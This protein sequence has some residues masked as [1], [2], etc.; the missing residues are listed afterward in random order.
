MGAFTFLDDEQTKQSGGSFTFLDNGAESDSSPASTIKN[1]G[2]GIIAGAGE[3]VANTEAAIGTFLQAPAANTLSGVVGARALADRG[4]TAAINAVSPGSAKV[5]PEY[6]ESAQ[7]ASQF[8]AETRAE[9]A[10]P[11]IGA[12]VARALEEDGRSRAQ[13]IQNFNR[14]N[15]PELIRQQ[16]ATAEAEGFVDNLKAI[17]DNPLAFANTMARSAPDMALGA[18]VARKVAQ[19]VAAAGGSA[20][21]QVGA[22]ST[23]GMLSEAGSSAMQ[24]REGVYQQV[25]AIPLTRLLES[26]R[27]QEILAKTKDPVQAREV[28]ANELADQAPLLAGTGTALGTIITNR[29]FGGDT[30]AKVLAGTER[31][32]AKDVAK[33]LAQES[34]EE[35]LQ[36]VPEDLA[37]HGAVVQAD[38]NKKFDVGGTLA[39]NM[40]A[41]AAMG[42][43]GTLAA[44][45]KQSYDDFK[46]GGP[47]DGQAAGTPPADTPTAADVLGVPESEQKQTAAEKAL[48][49]PKRL[50][51]LDRVEA[52]DTELQ[53][54]TPERSA[55]LI[56]EREAI[57]K[58]WPA[59]VEGGETTFST[60][61]GA[62][63]GAKYALIEAGDL[64]TSHDENL[65]PSAVYPSELQPRE[66]D[67]HASEMQVSGIVQKLDPARLGLS[68][69]AA[70]GAPI[71]GADGLVESGNARSI[72]LKRIY[73]AN[74]QKA[75]DYKTFIRSNAAQFGI[76]PAAVDAMQ[77]PVLVRVR[78]TPVN[79]A[80][81]ARQANA[82]TV[83]QMSPSEQARSD[84]ARLDVLD[85][86]RPTEDGDFSTSRDFIRRFMAK[87]PAT[88]QAGML[89]S[90]GQLSQTG[91]ARIRNAVLAKAYG[92]SPVLVRMVESMDDNLRNI[93]KALMQAAP[94]VAKVRQ[95]VADGALFDADITPDLMAAVEE[96]SVLRDGGRSVQDALAQAGMFGDKYS[97]ETRDL[98]QF[99]DE[100]IRRPKQMAEF[101][102]RY[103]EALRAAGNPNQGS[104]LGE[105]AAPNKGDLLTAAKR[106][107]D[108]VERP[109]SG[110]GAGTE[111]RGKSEVAQGHQGSAQGDESQSEWV[112][113]PP[114]TGTLGIPR[115]EMP[116]VKGD[117]RGAL[118]QFLEARRI[119]NKTIEEYPSDELK[120]TQAEFST[121]KTEGWKDVKEGSDRS[122][123][124]S[125]DGYILDGH[126][127]WMAALAT[128]EPI[129]AI[130][131]D[132]PIRELLAAV[133]Q[134]PST[135]RSTESASDAKRTKARED[136]DA[137]L[138]ELG[139]FFRQLSPGV[140][141][142]TPE[143]KAKLMP[144]LVKL[145]EAGIKEIGYNIKDLI[146][147]VKKAM[148]SRPELKAFWNRVDEATYR[149][150]AKSAVDNAINGLAEPAGQGDLFSLPERRAAQQDLF[151][152]MA[153]EA[154]KVAM[155]DGRP[156]DMKRD[157]FSPPDPSTFIG[158]QQLSDA[159]ALIDRFFSGSAQPVV[160]I[161]EAEKEQARTALAP[162]IELAETGKVRFDQAIID[163]A[164]NHGIG[165]LI[166]PIKT[167]DSA[168]RKVV[169]EYQGDASKVADLL[170]ATVVVERYDDAAA[171]IKAL[172]KQFDVVN[173]KNKAAADLSNIGTDL[174]AK[175]KN[176]DRAVFGGYADV[177]V[178]IRDGSGVLAEVQI[179]IPAMLAIKD[180]EGHR[181]YEAARVQSDGSQEKTALNSAMQE[182]YGAAFAADTLRAS[183]AQFKNAASDDAWHLETGSPRMAASSTLS[184]S[185]RNQEP[186]GNLTNSSP[187]NDDRNSQPSGNLSGTFISGTS[188]ES[189]AENTALNDLDHFTLTRLDQ[190]TQRM[191]PVTF[192]RGE[193]VR[194]LL[195]G[196]KE[197]FGEIDGI[198]HARREFSVDGL[199]YPFG[200]AYKA[201]RPEEKKRANAVPLSSVID[202][203]N[204]KFGEGLT[205]D[206]RVPPA[207]NGEAGI[208]PEWDS[209]AEFW[210]GLLEGKGSIADL[211]A[212]FATILDRAEEFKASIGKMKNDQLKRMLGWS[213]RPGDKKDALVDKVYDAALRRFVLDKNVPSMQWSYGE[214]YAKVKRDHNEKIRAI[215]NDLTDADLQAFR[216]SI[217]EADQ[218]KKAAHE[219]A[220]AAA[221]DPKTAEDFATYWNVARAEGKSLDEAR[222]A[223]TPEQRAA[224]DAFEASKTREARQA[225]GDQQKAEVKVAAQTTGGTIV[226]G[227]HTKHG[228]PLWSVQLSE[229]VDGDSYKTLLSTAKR[230]GGNYV[231]AMQ[232][233]MWKTVWG[234]QF[235]EQP[236]AEAFLK[237][238]GGESG[239]ARAVVQDR[240]DAFADDRSQSAVER[241]SEMAGRLDEQAD[242]SLG[243]ERKANTER[244][245]RFA[246]SAEAA[247]RAD[248]ALAATMRHIAD[249]IGSG[250]AKFLDR[251][252]QK[253]QV[254]MLAQT[255]RSAKDD[256][257]RAKYPSYGD[258][259]K[260][261]G[262]KPTIDTVEF[263]TWPRYTLFRSD[264]ATLGRQLLDVDGT[265]KLGQQLLKVADDVTDVYKKF[266]KENLHKVS[267]FSTKHPGSETVL[268]AVFSSSDA[269]ER[270]IARSGF[271]GKATTIS[272][273]RG[274]HL[275]IMGPSMARE[276]G[277][278]SGDDDKRITLS[279][280]FG[281]ELVEKVGRRSG[282]RS[283]LPAVPW[284][285]ANAYDKRKKLAA[286]GIETPFEFRA[287]LREFIALQQAPAEADKIKQMERAMIGR[288]ND[289]LDFFP[290]S[291]VVAD[292]MIDV[293]ELKPK[294]ST[295][296]PQAGMG[297]I[298][299]RIRQAGVE[300]DV[301]ELSQE[302]RELLE[303]KG[304]NV[305][306]QDFLAM[307]MSDTPNGEGY[308]RIIMN[309]PFSDRRD[310]EHVRHA[311]TLLKPGGRLVA[312]MGEG[313]FFGQD[314]KAA[315][316]RSWLDEVVGNSEKLPEGSFLDPSL[317]VN[318][319]VNARM[320]VVDKEADSVSNDGRLDQNDSNIA[321]SRGTGSGMSVR[322][323]KAVR[324]RVSERM[325]NLPPVNVLE[326]PAHAPEELRDFIEK[327]GA[328]SDVEGAMHDGEIYLFASGL[329][330]EERAEFVLATHEITHYGLRGRYGLGLDSVLQQIWLNNA[331]VRKAAT[332]LREKNGLGSNLEA[333]E[334]VLADM[335]SEDLV[336]LKGWRK[337]VAKVRDWFDRHGFEKLTEKLNRLLN[338]GLAEQ[339]Q[340]DVMVADV[341]RQARGFVESGRRGSGKYGTG[342]RLA[343]VPMSRKSG[344]EDP[345]N[346]QL[347]RAPT[348]TDV[349]KR[350]D[351]IIAKP[352]ASARPID[353]VVKAL[354]KSVRVDRMTLWAYNKAGALIDRLVPEHVKAGVVSDYGVPEAVIDRRTMMQGSMR[355]QVRG[356]GE[357][358]DK[359]ATL[360]REESRVAYEWMNN[361]DPQAAEYFEKQLPPESLKVMA[362]VKTLID[363][364]SQEAVKLGQLDPESFKRNRYEYLRRSYFKHTAELTKGEAEKRGRAISILGDQYKGRGMVDSVAMSKFRNVAPEWWGRKLQDG[365]AD[366][367]LKGE[368]FARLERRAPVGEGT[369]PLEQKHG[370][371][372]VDPLK[373]GRLLEVVYWPANE[374]VPAK[375][376]TW[377]HAGTWE[378]RDTKGG[379]LVLWRDFTKQER[380]AMGEIDEARFAIAKTLHGM[381]HD[382]E[383]GK[384]LE[385]LA[386]NHAQKDASQVTGKL[387]EATDRMRDTYGK[388]E[389]VQVPETTISGTSVKKYGALAGRYLPG[390][391]WNDVRQTV[392]FRFEPF[393]ETYAAILGAWKTSK[394]ALSPA[395]HTNNV[396][397][398]M[399][400]ADWHDVTA[401][402][403]VKALRL[404]LAA[405]DR[406]GEGAIGR[407]GNVVAKAGIADQ[408]AA[409][410]ILERFAESGGNIGT[411]AT[412]ELQKEQ[413]EPLLKALENEIATVA[414]SQPAQVGAMVALQKA[415]QLRFPS[416]WEAFK[417]T[418]AGKAL[419]TEARNMLDLYEAEDQVFRLAAWLRAKE[420]GASDIEAG[421]SARKSFLDY[422]IN[423]PWIQ[424]MRK[425]A[426]PFISFT[427]R[428]IPMLLETAATK[429]WKLLK[430]G[431]MAGALNM[432]GYLLSGGD[433]D[434]E[435][436]Y[437]PEEKAGRVLGV[438]PKLIRM[439][440]ND[441]N[442]SPVFLDIRR[443]VPV[444]DFLD[445]GQSHSAIPLIPS[446]VPGGVLSIMG[447]LV[448]NK[449]QFTGKEITRDTDTATEKTLKVV[450]HLYKAFAPN[451]VILPGTYAFQGVVDAGRGKTD[452]F[453]REQSTPAAVASSFGI[454]LGSYPTDVLRQ[455]ARRKMHS[456]KMEVQQGIRQLGREIRR[457]GID[458]DEYREK[459]EAQKEKKREIVQKFR[460]R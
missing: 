82:S 299:E 341:V 183:D 414:R 413:L 226:E 231:N 439:P 408:E 366:K 133:H 364:L 109:G 111:S 130:Q 267:V 101:I 284:Q 113:Y 106:G 33:N 319:G 410:V 448:L 49:E 138:A 131:F 159:R 363:Q 172:S 396:M 76:D 330:G 92:D 237:L 77:K 150:A 29:I 251:V 170:R 57:T 110:Q 31:T 67:R 13:S 182:I 306:G 301:V 35:G 86:L 264:L 19:S 434:D 425:T 112:V 136:F 318:T 386:I 167:M 336:K 389:W 74:G 348:T 258:Q 247:A 380:E 405:N 14:E 438:V 403:I 343:N 241:L 345:A 230:M 208:A 238:A 315:A 379:D 333:V 325:T 312:L 219:Q 195:S 157:N 456:E 156:Y 443:F 223:L 81:F 450:D 171:V 276:S 48:F 36:G 25:A 290:T 56:S 225:R 95:D 240:R 308:D 384:Y 394:T 374:P 125:S 436:R 72:A 457:N 437:L 342:T 354:T 175:T 132:A 263:A 395:V 421:K 93:G 85:D 349:E 368:K 129:K 7:L 339:Q 141:M 328:W 23:A 177:S 51:A 83:A 37:Q 96:L 287:A 358:I 227:V 303:A 367:G 122:V 32:T 12:R 160:Q 211:Q 291:G 97:P 166:A 28:L 152:S 352:A 420:E 429:P 121:K 137:A 244:R 71:I 215:V 252:R 422:N 310:A 59:T 206:D 338:A 262:E 128:K 427:Y 73:Q 217:S 391:I 66:R 266:A 288:K 256:E 190:K 20:A 424:A 22:A 89:D 191:A 103:T 324:D 373:K 209:F 281:A 283:N 271:N 337:L 116:Q 204:A 371:G 98:L 42:G 388:D 261:Q 332:A 350:A 139:A 435:R 236:V 119:P 44:Y 154:P 6:Q 3:G 2:L 320:V 47:A 451:I 329:S 117:A 207:E 176:Q 214:D 39:Q 201:D 107:D 192:E 151:A 406:K 381:V 146:A 140:R 184:S 78:T 9:N 91:Y 115:A 53:S 188:K 87:V 259:L 104:L 164:K 52:I 80:E 344:S 242:E 296:E 430:L 423:A 334:E 316:F 295:L 359:L 402:H 168:V 446:I 200:A 428:A 187:P 331:A 24:T 361:T 376:T 305:V 274:E 248:K 232:A 449:S 18:G 415:L 257:I 108:D 94:E 65:R 54:A 127:Q 278:W 155:I 441:A 149:D 365:K 385:W 279:P 221:A 313:V 185:N 300:P 431:M 222:K 179:N 282:K 362:E 346:T 243:R 253:L 102:R 409:R 174:L 173:I 64:V 378:V 353:A 340:A 126:H 419:T 100:N 46:R 322:D 198:S 63:V 416:A 270:A 375:M 193:Y 162:M 10:K 458:Q 43:G 347:S 84:A 302:R 307:N 212:V 220:K 235:R 369:M 401:G 8:A 356:A 75:E 40:A 393:G 26:P 387:V 142:L 239:E 234:F 15:N 213:A 400:M 280:D 79:R 407:A 169:G 123:L 178:I 289:G 41:G 383:T 16:Q 196:K 145:F 454:K 180:A 163:V 399:V 377:E 114:A 62:R 412:A 60:E 357:L 321:L 118:I 38:P 390:P 351:A 255:V 459:V 398:N 153:P 61:A 298:A 292:E 309:P 370:P 205:E 203:A 460:D 229:R 311:Y 58:G 335:P 326:S 120:P 17:K 285:F 249:A 216:N 181:L 55:E 90:S 432:L 189:I 11:G 45:G 327:A 444:G 135:K 447:E 21:A 99:L 317:P 304:F 148:R 268:P 134:F 418:K 286:L 265:R 5:N 27:Y 34:T 426:F 50:T 452:T 199:W 433:E 228:Y 442:G 245:A 124:I 144:A 397:A 70:T 272:F 88:E 165:Q 194:Y 254:E 269:A 297:H 417:G 147:H 224:W 445:A 158:A 355:R 372:R 143:E 323:L 69:D 68:A 105:T 233:R 440:W 218:K 202:K 294:M 1:Y 404:V 186:S 275:V 250:T 455:N 392:G 411:W 293:A 161:S 382:V 30:T 360:T 210:N 277:V 314:K 260:H 453:G 273:K 197:A 246:A 4:I